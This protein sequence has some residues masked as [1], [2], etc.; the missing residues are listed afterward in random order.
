MV[1]TAVSNCQNYFAAGFAT[2]SVAIFT[3]RELEQL[4]YCNAHSN[5]VTGIEFL[6]RR[7]LD[8]PNMGRIEQNGNQIPQ[9]FLPGVTSEFMVSLVSI[10]MDKVVKVHQVPYPNGFSSSGFWLKASFWMAAFYLL[11]WTIFY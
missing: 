7:T 8:T 6:P 9:T 4:Y 3:T 5:S 10:S 1:V 2:G 11:L